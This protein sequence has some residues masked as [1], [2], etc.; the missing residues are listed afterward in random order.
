MIEI[1]WTIFLQAAIFAV[2]LVV[3]NS[4]LFRPLRDVFQRR[5]ESIDGSV[6]RAKELEGQINEK[7]TRY[8]ERLQ[9]AKLNGAQEKAALRQEAMLEEGKI[10]SAAHESASV[11]VQAI[12]GK[13]RDEAESAR[14][15]LKGEARG[16]ASAIASKVWGRAL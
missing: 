1:N 7:M 9:E 4:V 15:A 2:L 8:Q 14:E 11:H 5:T 10:L 13:V 6:R 3:L 16:L 12:R